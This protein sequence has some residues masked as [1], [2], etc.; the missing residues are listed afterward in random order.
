MRP[1]SGVCLPAT[2]GS[3]WVYLRMAERSRYGK[4]Q[5]EKLAWQVGFPRTPD[6]PGPGAGGRQWRGGPSPP[7]N[8]PWVHFPINCWFLLAEI[9]C[10]I[11]MILS[12]LAWATSQGIWSDNSAA[13]VPSSDEKVNTPIWSNCWV[14]TKS[15]KCSKCSDNTVLPVKTILNCSPVGCNY[16]LN[17]KNGLGQGRR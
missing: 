10:C 17:D 14:S 12:F 1:R 8:T 4:P 9:G 15:T 2:P 3:G 13:W 7:P 6:P 11:E 5:Y 16:E